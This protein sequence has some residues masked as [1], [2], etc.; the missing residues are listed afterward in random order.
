VVSRGYGL[1]MNPGGFAGTM[2]VK[3]RM[4]FRIPEGLGLREAAL[5]EPCDKVISST[6]PLDR[7]QEA[8]EMLRGSG[9]M[10]VLI[11]CRQG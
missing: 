3:P 4:L 2:R 11:D 8:L 7:I 5:N 9:Q 1:G 6:L 10:K